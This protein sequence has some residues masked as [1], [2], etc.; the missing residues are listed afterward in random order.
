MMKNPYF[1]TEEVPLYQSSNQFFVSTVAEIDD[2]ISLKNFC[3]KQRLKVTEYRG[4]MVEHTYFQKAK[5]MTDAF[6]WNKVK[7]L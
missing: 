5:E 1:T 7:Y 4:V 3:E 2:G 6:L